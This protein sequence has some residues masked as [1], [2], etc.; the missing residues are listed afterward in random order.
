MSITSLVKRARHRWLIP[1]CV[2]FGCVRTCMCRWPTRAWGL[3]LAPA[4][5]GMAPGSARAFGGAVDCAV[6]A[7]VALSR[8]SASAPLW[9]QA[10][11]GW[12]STPSTVD[13]AR[14][15]PCF[16]K[17]R[18]WC[19]LGSRMHERIYLHAPTRTLSRPTHTHAQSHTHTH[20]HTHTRTHTQ[21]HT[22]TCVCHIQTHARTRTHIEGFI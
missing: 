6:C 11:Q 19:H 21:A 14:G 4:P 2:L 3:P 10:G 20:T 18:T 13:A 15:A 5:G 9:W 7:L 17:Q 1:L 16:G 8:R 12:W 22:H